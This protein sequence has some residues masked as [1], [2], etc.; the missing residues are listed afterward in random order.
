MLT[1]MP[2]GEYSLPGRQRSGLR[3]LEGVTQPARATAPGPVQRASRCA[4]AGE[5]DRGPDVGRL[6]A[7]AGRRHRVLAFVSQDG[8][9]EALLV[10]D[11]RPFAFPQ[12]RRLLRG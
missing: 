11:V 6:R 5:R 4:R 8:S 12:E 1:S 10:V 2:V 7:A 9:D 3:A